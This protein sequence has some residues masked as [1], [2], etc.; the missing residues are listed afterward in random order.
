VIPIHT[1][2]GVLLVTFALIG[3]LRG[4]A[5][6][7]VVIFSV[8]LA[9][10]VEHVLLTFLPPVARLFQGMAPKSQFYARTV[11]F[12]IISVLGYA[13]PALVRQLGDRVVRKRLQ[14]VL[15]GFFLGLI[16]GYLIVGTILSFLHSANYGI[17]SDQPGATGIGGAVPPAAETTAANLVEVLPPV[18]IAKSNVVL[19]IAVA[20]ALLLVI[21]LFI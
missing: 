19:Y 4:W 5:K 11:L 13:S 7:A 3:G 21:V 1:L 14:D 18:L 20:L 15:L 17:A 2:F 9:L 12:V 10:F 16:N 6:E 8:I